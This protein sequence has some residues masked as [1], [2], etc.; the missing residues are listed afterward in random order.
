[1][2]TNQNTG[3]DI[4]LNVSFRNAMIRFGVMMLLLVITLLIDKKWII[5]IVPV[6]AYLFITAIIRFCIIKYAWHRYIRHEPVPG[7]LPYGKNPN[8]PDETI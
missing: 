5:Y 3:K 7:P 2:K 1:M 8:F 4:R 6:L